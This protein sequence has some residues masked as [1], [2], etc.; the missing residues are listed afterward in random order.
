MEERL[1]DGDGVSR[2][3]EFKVN[4]NVSPFQMDICLAKCGAP[5]SKYTT[6]FSIYRFIDNGRL[7]IRSS[8]RSN[9][10]EQFKEGALDEH[11]MILT[12]VE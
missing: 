4:Q 5:G 2:K 11:T 7:E 6:S 8:P 1:Q 10:P 3:G 9:Y 12:R